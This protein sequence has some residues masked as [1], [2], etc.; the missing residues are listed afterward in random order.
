MRALLPLIV[1]SLLT[2]CAPPPAPEPST[3]AN[4]HFDAAPMPFVRYGQRGTAGA[5]ELPIPPK[6]PLGTSAVPV[7]NSPARGSIVTGLREAF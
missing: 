2:A 4:R 6:M 3:Q 5:L 7:S 1:A